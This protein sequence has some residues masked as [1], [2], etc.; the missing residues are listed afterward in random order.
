MSQD[1]GIVKEEPRARNPAVLR[2]I[3]FENYLTRP[4]SPHP[5][6]RLPEAGRQRCQL[7]WSCEGGLLASATGARS[8]AH[9]PINHLL[10][11][12]HGGHISKLSTA[13]DL[14]GLCLVRLR[15]QAWPWSSG[16]GCDPG[17]RPLCSTFVPCF[18]VVV[19]A[20][21]TWESQ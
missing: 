5:C 7:F 19:G 9:V 12:G 10:I 15:C 13:R 1:P 14:P 18:H 21:T 6:P 11:P 4:P 3:G 20:R 16:R 17:G 8:L 2:A